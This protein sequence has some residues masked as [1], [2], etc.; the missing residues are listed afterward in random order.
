[1]GVLAGPGSASCQGTLSPDHLMPLP[2]N[3]VPYIYPVPYTCIMYPILVSCTLY[4][5][6]VYP[7]PVSCTLYLCHVPYTCVMYPTPVSCTLYLCHVPYT[8][9]MYP[10]PV[11]C[12]LY[13]CHHHHHQKAFRNISHT[14]HGHRPGLKINKIK[15]K[16][17][18]IN[19]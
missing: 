1:M 19:Y 16:I 18:T 15:G 10:I 5:C 14:S 9:V 8:C 4:L 6:H 12:T 11:S 17:L 2:L 7:I 3:P 13:L